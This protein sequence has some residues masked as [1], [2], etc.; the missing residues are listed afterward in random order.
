M[1]ASAVDAGQRGDI[2]QVPVALRVVE[3]VADGELVGDLEADVAGVGLDLAPLG[4]GQQRADLQRGRLAGLERSHQVLQRQPGV[5]DV[6]H[7]QDVA[8]LE[9]G[10]EVLE[11]PHDAG[12]VRRGAVGGDGHEV[13]LARDLDLAHQ[14]AEEEDGALE[15]ADQEQVLVRVVAGDLGAEL[16]DAVLQVVGLDDDLADGFVAQHGRA[17][18]GGGAAGGSQVSLARRRVPA[19]TLK[20]SPVA[21]PG[22]QA[23]SSPETTTGVRSRRARGILRSVKRSCSERLPPSPSGRIRSPGR[24][25]RT[26][27]GAASASRSRVP[28]PIA[29]SAPTSQLSSPPANAARPGTP[30]GAGVAAAAG[31]VAAGRSKRRRPYSAI[32]RRPPPRSSAALPA[33]PPSASSSAARAPTAGAAPAAASSARRCRHSRPSAGGSAASAACSSVSAASTAASSTAASSRSSASVRRTFASAAGCS[34]RS[35]GSSRSRTRLRA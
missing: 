27:S 18:Y 4:L 6:L 22:T 1:N 11:D 16:A 29:R 21:T 31:E 3:P 35:A 33:P 15:D 14:V 9:R 5:H 34:P 10:V 12:G 24:H 20:R 17:V 30:S 25:D 19:P 7:D 2:R 32:A 23:I 13:D 8:A 26:A 28:S